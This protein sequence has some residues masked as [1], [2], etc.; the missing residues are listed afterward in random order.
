MQSWG[1]LF[2]IFFLQDGNQILIKFSTSS[3]GCLNVL[4]LS[5]FILEARRARGPFCKR[6]L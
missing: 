2:L 4:Q 1:R 5:V 6:G 3:P